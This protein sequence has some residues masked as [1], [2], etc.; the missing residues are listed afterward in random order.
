MRPEEDER[1]YAEIETE[2]VRGEFKR[3]RDTSIK[4]CVR[5]VSLRQTYAGLLSKLAARFLP[6]RISRSRFFREKKAL[7]G[8]NLV[9]EDNTCVSLLGHNGAGKSTT[10]NILTGLFQQTSGEAYIAGYSTRTDIQRIRKIL[11]MCP[12]HDILWDDLTAEEHLEL[13][14]DMKGVARKA[15]NEEVRTLLES[16]DL[17]DV[18]HH[19]TKTYSGGMK[20]RLS[21]CIACIGNPKLVLLDEPTT[22]LDPFS[23]KKAWNLIHKMKKGRALILTTHQ[24]D[25]ADFLSDRI[26]I[27][28]HGQLKCIGDSLSI[29]SMYGSGYNLLLVANVGQEKSVISLVRNYVPDCKLVSQGAGNYIF[30]VPKESITELGQLISYIEELTAKKDN[31][32]VLL[33]DWGISQT[34]LEEV[35]LK[36]TKKSEFGYKT[37]EGS[38]A[39]L[40][41]M[42]EEMV[43][44]KELIPH[45]DSQIIAVPSVPSEME[46][47]ETSPANE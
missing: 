2:D 7:R 1:D 31:T 19:L 28:A 37:S 5:I 21:I 4:A 23:R 11:G 15:R 27:M 46:L 30:N 10:M 18:G 13:F 22:G 43:E 9:V 24:M 32:E 25:E 34:T 45:V 44:E 12:Q 42:G 41:E 47:R 29:K 40:S 35:Y 14:G 16:V 6:E 26:A 8:L 20:R 36:V 38:Q 33:K 39:N 17:L 3:A